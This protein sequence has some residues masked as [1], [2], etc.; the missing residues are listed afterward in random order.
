M[1]EKE[2][3]PYLDGLKQE[4]VDQVIDNLRKRNEEFKQQ[5]LKKR[6]SH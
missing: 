6:T 4:V 1:T 2:I 5:S 3:L